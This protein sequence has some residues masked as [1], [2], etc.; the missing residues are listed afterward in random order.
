[1]TKP[2]QDYN[3][4]DPVLI[5]GGRWKGRTGRIVSQPLSSAYVR[6]DGSV[7]WIEVIHHDDL[8]LRDPVSALGDLAE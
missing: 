8:E 6:L 2:H 4:G 7:D 3:P 1:M 5:V